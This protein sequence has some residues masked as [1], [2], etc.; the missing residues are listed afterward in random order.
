MSRNYYYLIAG[1]PDLVPEEKKMT[2]SSVQFKELLREELSNSDNQLVHLFFLPFDHQNLLNLFFKIENG[3]DE[4]GN[5]ALEDLE[6]LVDR[7]TLDSID[8]SSYPSYL[9]QFVL[10]L[11][12]EE[13][14]EN[15]P[16]AERLITQA[17]YDYLDASSNQGVRAISQ[18]QRNVGNVMA[19]LNARKHQI[20]PET[21]LVGSGEVIESLRKSRARDFGLSSEV[22]Y[23]EDLVQIFET[24]NLKDREMKLDMHKWAYLEEITFFNYFTIEKVVAFLL[25]LFIV[26]RWL[27]LD[28]TKGRE[29]FE[30][31]FDELKSGFEFPEEYTLTYARRK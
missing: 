25:K 1:L 10:T 23:I 17:Y 28:P 27:N 30:K 20:D 18:Y 7:K 12:S 31:L 19:A 15:R 5:Y 26:E 9:G 6:P 3:W 11:H 14:P 16:D 2:F 21:I 29:M 8:L 4:R 13:G 22:D 24:D